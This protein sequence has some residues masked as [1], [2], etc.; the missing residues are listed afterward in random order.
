MID[1][2]ED[3]LGGRARSLLEQ[4]WAS[5]SRNRAFLSN[6]IPVGLSLGLLRLHVTGFGGR[7]LHLY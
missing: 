3:G 5:L 7:L 4:Y 1:H 2:T 6:P